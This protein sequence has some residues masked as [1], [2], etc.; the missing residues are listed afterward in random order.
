MKLNVEFEP[1][2]AQLG[3]SLVAQVGA[4]RCSRKAAML[5]G[6]NLGQLGADLDQLGANLRPTWGQLVALI[7]R[8]GGQLIRFTFVFAWF[9]LCP[10]IHLGS[11]VRATS[12]LTY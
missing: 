1:N 8:G 9:T 5:N 10:E 6:A 11:F 7:W 12:S 4:P 3:G 2:L